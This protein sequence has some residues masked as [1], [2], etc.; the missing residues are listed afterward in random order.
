MKR[1]G[2]EGGEQAAEAAEPKRFV[3]EDTPPAR[4]TEGPEAKPPPVPRGRDR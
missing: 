1:V 4:P 3:K 2:E